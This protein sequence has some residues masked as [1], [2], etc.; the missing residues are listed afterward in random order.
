METS[1]LIPAL[2]VPLLSTLVAFG[3]EIFSLRS[4]VDFF[5]F[6]AVIILTTF[7]M[8]V[9]HSIWS[10]GY[11]LSLF[12]ALTFSAVYLLPVIVLMIALE[13]YPTGNLDS[14]ALGIFLTLA[15][16]PLSFSHRL[17]RTRRATAVRIAWAVA[18]VSGALLL[19]L[20]LHVIWDSALYL[21]MIVLVMI[22]AWFYPQV[23]RLLKVRSNFYGVV[24]VP[25][26]VWFLLLGLIPPAVL[27][28]DVIAPAFVASALLAYTLT[29]FS[30][31]FVQIE[32]EHLSEPQIFVA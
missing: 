11:G 28:P 8:H 4:S 32:L 25:V 13:Y 19:G 30:K 23:T 26:G 5:T 21:G 20:G 7:S 3:V 17:I 16:L 24:N 2:I 18:M 15:I 12:V 9:C 1:K 31:T 14:I 6:W 22:V 27:F 29:L 10:R